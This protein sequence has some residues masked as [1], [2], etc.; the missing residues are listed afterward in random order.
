MK[1]ER[2]KMS[3]TLPMTGITI[4]KQSGKEESLPVYPV[5]PPITVSVAVAPITATYLGLSI[6]HAL[7]A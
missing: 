6:S 7:N 1:K 4:D 5:T 3:L 2:E